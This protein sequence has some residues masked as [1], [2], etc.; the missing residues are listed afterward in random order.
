V[1]AIENIWEKR[2]RNW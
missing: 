2:E 1:K